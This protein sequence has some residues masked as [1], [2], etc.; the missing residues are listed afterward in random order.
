M[1]EGPKEVWEKELSF[2]CNSFAALNN[3]TQVMLRLVGRYLVLLMGEVLSR[4]KYPS[5]DVEK[6]MGIQVPMRIIENF[7]RRKS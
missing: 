6:K 5:R 7:T 3:S 2:A 1:I 4:C